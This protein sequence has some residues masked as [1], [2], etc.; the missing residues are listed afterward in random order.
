MTDESVGKCFW[1]NSLYKRLTLQS[2][3]LFIDHRQALLPLNIGLSKRVYPRTRMKLQETK[4]LQYWCPS[5]SW[6]SGIATKFSL[7]WR[8]FGGMK[9]QKFRGNCKVRI[10]NHRWDNLEFVAKSGKR[11]LW[12]SSSEVPPWEYRRLN[13]RWSTAAQF[14]S[15]LAPCAL[16]L[17]FYLAWSDLYFSKQ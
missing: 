14:F 11:G 12:G 15:Y 8:E 9:I 16:C 7:V 2:S 13:K 5:I 3:L 1:K 10:C 17:S 6:V 4:R